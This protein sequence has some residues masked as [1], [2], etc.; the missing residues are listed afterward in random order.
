MNTEDIKSQLGEYFKNGKVEFKSFIDTSPKQINAKII[1]PN[2]TE[3]VILNIFPQEDV[4]KFDFIADNQSVATIND[5]YDNTLGMTFT[6][7]F[8]PILRGIVNDKYELEGDVISDE[9]LGTDYC[10][11]RSEGIIP[12]VDLT[13][14]LEFTI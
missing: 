2:A 10:Q 12:F 4:V 6:Q 11:V 5:I 13:E 3:A 7:W 8:K 1:H 9:L 14:M